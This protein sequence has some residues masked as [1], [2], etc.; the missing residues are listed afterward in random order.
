M[1]KILSKIFGRD[2]AAPS[3][4]ISRIPDEEIIKELLASNPTPIWKKKALKKFLLLITSHLKKTESQR[5]IKQTLELLG[6]ADSPFDAISDSMISGENSQMRGQW[7]FIQ[8]DAKAEDEIQWQAEEIL[9]LFGIKEQW[10]HDCITN[11]IGTYK[12][13]YELSCWLSMR[14]LS[15][16]SLETDGDWY[17]SFIVEAD[18]VQAAT[19]LATSAG[20]VIYGDNDWAI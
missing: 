1:L 12:T 9:K 8:I 11:P 5:L 3:E 20:L 7:V 10:S 13:L 16:L 6:D 17:C 15:L 14:G 18:N 2:L 19:A 4:P